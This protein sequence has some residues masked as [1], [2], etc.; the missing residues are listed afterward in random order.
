MAMEFGASDVEGSHFII[1]DGDTF[2]IG[3][4]VHVAIDLES[5]VCRGRADQVDNGG[6]RPQRLATPVLADERKQALFDAVPFAGAGRQMANH[7]LDPQ[8]RGQLLQ[9]DLP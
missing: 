7:D 9:F 2:E 8:F 1:A 4:M 6:E 3:V 5:R